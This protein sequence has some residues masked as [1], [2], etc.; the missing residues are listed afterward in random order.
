MM[1]SL[2]FFDIHAYSLE[3]LYIILLHK[4][5]ILKPYFYH[6][7]CHKGAGAN[8]REKFVDITV[9]HVFLYTQRFRYE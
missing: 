9:I 3:K 4:G 8:G 7:Q 1:L 2:W 6:H 5:D